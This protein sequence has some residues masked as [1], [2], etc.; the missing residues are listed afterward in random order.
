MSFASLRRFIPRYFILSNEM[1][2]EIASLTS[3]FDISLLGYLH[4][5]WV[6]FFLLAGCVCM[7]KLAHQCT[8]GECSKGGEGQRLAGA[9][10]TDTMLEPIPSSRVPAWF[11]LMISSFSPKAWPV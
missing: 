2:H 3:L 8:L 6:G 5:S 9:H 11:V 1:I 7:Y 4:R 10:V